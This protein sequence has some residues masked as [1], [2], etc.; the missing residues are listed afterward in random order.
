MGRFVSLFMR[1]RFARRRDLAGREAQLLNSLG[2]TYNDVEHGNRAHR[3]FPAC[4]N[5]LRK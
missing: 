1:L 3:T 5:I 4:C 2:K